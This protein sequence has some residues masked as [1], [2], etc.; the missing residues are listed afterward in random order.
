M[1]CDVVRSAKAG[2]AARASSVRKKR[3]RQLP[4]GH[5]A[6]FVSESTEVPSPTYIRVS[7]FGSVA[8]ANSAR[9]VLNAAF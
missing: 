7:P 2:T 4:P 1:F 3:A 8:R 6:L 5:D 9:S